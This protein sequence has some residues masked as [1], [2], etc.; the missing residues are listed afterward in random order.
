MTL[1]LQDSSYNLFIAMS[2]IRFPIVENTKANISN[3]T[4]FFKDIIKKKF[5]NYKKILSERTNLENDDNFNKL[6]IPYA[7]FLFGSYDLLILSIVDDYDFSISYFN[8]FTQTKEHDDNFKPFTQNKKYNDNFHY[9]ILTNSKSAIPQEKDNNN[10][11]LI[12]LFD[13][14]SNKSNNPDLNKKYNFVSISLFK[15]NNSLLFGIGNILIISLK[16]YI[17]RLLESKEVYKENL[18]LV[19]NDSL[20]YNE[21]NL[22]YFSSSWEIINDFNLHLRELNLKEMMEKTENMDFGA[23]TFSFNSLYQKFDTNILYT[24][25][26]ETSTSYWGIRYDLCLNQNCFNED[27]Q[28]SINNVDKQICPCYI[29]K[30]NPLN[31]DCNNEVKQDGKKNDDKQ[32]CPCNINT[33]DSLKQ[34]YFNVEKIFER[35]KDQIIDNLV[36]NVNIEFYTRW[37][38]K[39]GHMNDFITFMTEIAKELDKIIIIKKDLFLKKYHLT[40][41]EKLYDNKFISIGFGDVIFPNITADNFFINN[42]FKVSNANFLING[43]CRASNIVKKRNRNK[44]IKDVQKH[45]LIQRISILISSFFEKEI[46][47]NCTQWYTAPNISN[48]SIFDNKDKEIDKTKHLYFLTFLHDFC[49]NSNDIQKVREKLREN[50]SSRVLRERVSR[51]MTNYNDGMLDSLLY[52]FFADLKI[53][54]D[55]LIKRIKNNDLNSQSSYNYREYLNETLVYLEEALRIR[56]HKNYRFLENSDF[57]LEYEGGLQNLITAFNN[58]YQN[59]SAVLGYPGSFVNITGNSIVESKEY[60]MRINYYHI[61]HPEIFAIEANHEAL[62][63][64][65]KSNLPDNRDISVNNLILYFKSNL[66]LETFYLNKSEELNQIV[67]TLLKT[68]YYEYSNVE[69]GR[70]LPII[71]DTECINAIF[72]DMFNFCLI[73]N[74]DENLFQTMM[75]SYFSQLSTVYDDLNVINEEKFSV[76]YFRLLTI[77]NAYNFQINLENNRILKQLFDRQP[78]L[79]NICLVISDV[80][81]VISQITTFKTWINSSVSLIKEYFVFL[82]DDFD[83]NNLSNKDFL[84]VIKKREIRLENISYPDF[85]YEEHNALFITSKTLNSFFFSNEFSINKVYIKLYKHLLKSRRIKCSLFNK[86]LNISGLKENKLLK[87][88]LLEMFN[89][90]DESFMKN[91]EIV[92]Q[93][94]HLQFEFKQYFYYINDEYSKYKT[95]NNFN[96]IIEEVNKIISIKKSFKKR[97]AKRLKKGKFQKISL[98][99]K[100]FSST[101]FTFFFLTKENKIFLRLLSFELNWPDKPDKNE[102][103]YKFYFDLYESFEQN[104]EIDK[105]YR[106]KCNESK[107]FYTYVSFEDFLAFYHVYLLNKNFHD[108]FFVNYLFCKLSLNTC[109]EF[110]S[111]FCDKNSFV[112]IQDLFNIYLQKICKVINN[113]ELNL[114]P[115]KKDGETGVINKNQSNYMLDQQGRICVY[116]KESRKNYLSD[117]IEFIN[118][119]INLSSIKKLNIFLKKY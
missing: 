95:R 21:I 85:S 7:Y 102:E 51:F 8:P 33:V 68:L 30:V 37:S 13:N 52:G 112:Y 94:H 57:M 38:V 101:L 55:D 60:M 24:H 106:D 61:F 113:S 23:F 5:F 119:L 78:N 90:W 27:K 16:N 75:W 32:K 69:I 11:V 39:P 88:D 86:I 103:L 56:L 15:V 110:A 73:F 98:F 41:N 79:K 1:K 29:N 62:N 96:K 36:K 72:A 6:Y 28:D 17:I 83:V 20:S 80:Y 3:N 2:N 9:Q 108:K 107:I 81:N 74:L 44:S 43:P 109:L 115:R 67:Q 19:I 118:Q 66:D 35:Q 99:S 100:G 77:L 116:D 84:Q 97:R 25:I 49:I 111:N 70:I 22:L 50:N 42:P 63:W 71:F 58:V 89:F 31:Q 10:D 114:F 47:T 12:D 65:N 4:C 48:N 45:L 104:V 26:F 34:I 105:I 87:N 18:I 54:V 40:Y 82:F 14:M 53:F 64:F 117:R 59:I 91:I 92:F 76:F 93:K 46:Y